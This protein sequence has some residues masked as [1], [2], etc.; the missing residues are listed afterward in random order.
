M[1]DGLQN[2]QGGFPIGQAILQSLIYADLFDFPLTA[3]EIHRYLP[4]SPIS[5]TFL[6]NTLEDGFA[7]HHLSQADGYFALAGR[8]EIIPIRQ[9]R[10][11]I[12]GR[13]WARA[14]RYA[15]IIACIPFVRMIAVTGTL[16]VENV[17]SGDDIDYLIVTAP[18][19]LWL[20]RALVIGLVRLA[21][22]AGDELCPNYFLSERMLEIPVRNLFTARE[23]LQMVPLYG[24]ATYA[25]FRS[26]NSWTTAFFPNA[27]TPPACDVLRQVDGPF[28]AKVQRVWE[29][30]LSGPWGNWLEQGEM[31]R[32]ILRL[33]RQAETAGLSPS[34]G[35]TIF[36]TDCCKG[37]FEG[38]DELILERYRAGLQ[39]HGLGPELQLVQGGSH[40]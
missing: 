23:L 1:F 28:K 21:R 26:A 25:R 8:K 17:K 38:Y 32:K 11:E 9:Q 29:K 37:H 15:A 36:T 18:G 30:A 27:S 16:A 2:Q 33:S 34:Q 35:A 12:A 22:L 39:A 4:G 14:H 5:A 24:P 6:H 7:R 13:L 31:R 3:D 40:E 19:R 10:R 20:C